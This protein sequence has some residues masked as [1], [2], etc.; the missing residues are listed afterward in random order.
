MS[1]ESPYCRTD[2]ILHDIIVELYSVESR[3]SSKQRMGF[4]VRTR[5]RMDELWR[6]VPEE[7]KTNATGLAPPPYLFMFQ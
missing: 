4:V 2:K 3:L 7:M 6:S 5:L 1:G